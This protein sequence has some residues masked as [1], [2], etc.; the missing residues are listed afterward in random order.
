MLP[1]ASLQTVNNVGSTD[2]RRVDAFDI[3]RFPIV[4]AS[5]MQQD[6]AW[7]NRRVILFWLLVPTSASGLLAMGM[8]HLTPPSH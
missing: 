5:P 3:G 1:H 4:G 8:I 6:R 7:P 2:R